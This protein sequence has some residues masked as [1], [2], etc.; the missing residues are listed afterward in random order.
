M[1]KLIC[2][3]LALALV[4]TAAACGKTKQNTEVPGASTGSAAGAEGQTG[5]DP[6]AAGADNTGAPDTGKTVEELI[7]EKNNPDAV[8]EAEGV[9][10]G[11]KKGLKTYLFIGVDHRNDGVEAGQTVETGNSDVMHLYIVD[12][13]N[14]Q[15]RVLELNR[16]TVVTVDILNAYGTVVGQT[17]QQLSF[18]F[19]Y[20]IDAKA[21]CENVVRAISNLLGGI[22]VDGYAALYM[23]SI[24]PLNDAVGGV[25]V[26][27]ED[28]FSAMDPTLV[29]GETV[30][31]EGQHA[32]NF[33]RG[34]MSVGD[35]SNA[36]RM[37]R[38]R[39][40]MNALTAKIRSEV[41]N[42]HSGIVNDL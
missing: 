21:N 1:K 29:M 12:E 14:K 4:F 34:R 6:A 41:K 13:A 38:Q 24:I 37:R 7:E 18:A 35:G 15:Y 22:Q 42:G 3:L 31:L 30:H 11:L 2:L 27:I 36:S 5:T 25:D 26:K 33:V 32:Q 20:S 10:Y 9:S 8:I 39:V 23:D 17:Q 19:G 40:Y 28:D 16:D